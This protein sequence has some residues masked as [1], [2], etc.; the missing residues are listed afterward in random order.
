MP[1]ISE[2]AKVL[3]TSEA[4]VKKLASEGKIGF[5]ALEQA[6][7]N[8]TTGSGKFA[9]LAAKTA[10]V[11]GSAARASAQWGAVLREI[12]NLLVPIKNAALDVF[13]SLAG[14]I[15]KLLNPTK[16]LNDS[17]GDQLKKVVDMDARLPGLLTKYTTLSQKT[18]LTKTEQTELNTTL[19]DLQKLVPGAV[20]EVDKYGNALAFNTDKIKAFQV[21]NKALFAETA[22]TQ[23]KVYED[24]LSKV[25]G[26]YEDLKKLAEG[27]PYRLLL[28]AVAARLVR[29]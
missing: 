24:E 20:T 27:Q 9:D 8:L 19:S 10:A 13:S 6:F 26:S 5:S 3:G 1:I 4:N 15:N 25:K 29:T 23:L 22:R 11:T 21:E 17:Y 16:A 7:D 2:F 14:G 18:T 28:A 12:G